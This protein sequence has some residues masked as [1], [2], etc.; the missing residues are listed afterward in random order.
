MLTTPAPAAEKTS[1]N[2]KNSI[3]SIRTWEKPP[4]YTSY[5]CIRS[6]T[7]LGLDANAQVYSHQVSFPRKSA[8]SGEDLV[9]IARNCAQK[10]PVPWGTRWFWAFKR[11]PLLTVGMCVFVYHIPNINGAL[12]WQK[13][14]KSALRSVSLPWIG[15]FFNFFDFNPNTPGFDLCY[16]LTF[17]LVIGND[18]RTLVG[19][20]SHCFVCEIEPQT[21]PHL[22]LGYG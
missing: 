10:H 16:I 1:K 21:E 14:V 7:R 13:V 15:L 4:Q 19:C 22:K 2:S 17:S 8:F 18:I 12:E 3:F 5:R 11:V 9:Q 20:A 6:G